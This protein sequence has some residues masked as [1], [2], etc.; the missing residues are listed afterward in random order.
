MPRLV[1][2][3]LPMAH[4]GDVS[5]L[6]TLIAGGTV[7]AASIRAVIGKTE[8][9]GG[10]NDFTRGYFTQS[11]MQLLARETG[12][13]AEDLAARIPCV[14]SGGTEGVLSP[15]YVVFAV[16]EA[17]GEAGLAI[18]TA[19]GP[20]V[21][22]G[23]VGNDAQIA[24]VADAVRAAMADAGIADA[25]DIALVQ[26]KSPAGGPGLLLRSV[27]GGA[28]GAAL[29]LGDVP[30]EEARGAALLERLDLFSPRVSASAGVEV[31]RDEV[32]VLG[33]AP[34]WAPGLRMAVRAM[35]D[36]LDLRAVQSA[37][38]AAGLETDPDVPEAQRPR[39][40]AV[41]AKGEP[42]RT[43]R[44]RGQRHTMLGDTD[45][46]AQRH[47]R[48]AV[49]AVIAAVAGDGRIFVSGGAAHQG[50]PGGGLVAVIAAEVA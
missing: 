19:F 21:A 2:H 30:A 34:G 49:G 5:A 37:F 14:L 33:K 9:N 23:D 12:E 46:D 16:E 8:G 38:R 17:A 26:V 7:P 43:L 25:S 10:L 48:G 32:V 15:H 22:P 6:A 35:A 44:I 50:P 11:L 18:G 4:P 39:I 45:I 29:A 24:R 13:A 27:A 36:A 31:E 1:I 3:R 42:D 20:P 41:L 47:L 40:R 28:M